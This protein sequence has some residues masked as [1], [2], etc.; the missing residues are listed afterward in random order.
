LAGRIE[1]VE[2]RNLVIND[3]LLAVGICTLAVTRRSHGASTATSVLTLDCRVILVDEVAL[4]E[5]YGQARLSDT[6][7][8]DHHELVFS[9]KLRRE[10]VTASR[11]RRQ[12]LRQKQ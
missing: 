5:L 2:Q 8:A 11:G 9:E 3:T 6:T 12:Q 4:D 10:S 7:T 1:H